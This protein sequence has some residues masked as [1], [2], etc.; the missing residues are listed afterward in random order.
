MK[1]FAHYCSADDDPK[2]VKLFELHGY[3]GT[4]I[5]WRLCAIV[6][7]MKNASG[8]TPEYLCIPRTLQQPYRCRTAAVRQV[9]RTLHQLDLIEAKEEGSD[10]II[11]IPKLNKYTDE[12]TKRNERERNPKR[13]DNVRAEETIKDHKRKE[14]KDLNGTTPASALGAEPSSPDQDPG[15]EAGIEDPKARAEAMK[16]IRAM[17]DKLNPGRPT[18]EEPVSTSVEK[19]SGNEKPEEPGEPLQVEPALMA[20]LHLTWA[21]INALG[22]EP[23]RAD[24]VCTLL[25]EYH[26]ARIDAF[27]LSY[28]L[29]GI[30]EPKEKLEVLKING[31]VARRSA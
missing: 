9:I 27:Q 22:I 5:Y 11:K 12:N 15:I 21:D 2:I 17:Q 7:G 30:L 1:Y 18:A 4:G 25:S 19:A 23:D 26:S 24:K 13:P 28:R 14:K 29:G 10:F 16:V 6:A 31:V 8:D 3:D 20:E